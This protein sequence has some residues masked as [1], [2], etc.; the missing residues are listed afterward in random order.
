MRRFG[1]EVVLHVSVFFMAA[2]GHAD[3]HS[4]VAMISAE[5][6]RFF[7]VGNPLVELNRVE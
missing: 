3:L 5:E 4:G 2:V 6:M 7:V 1:F